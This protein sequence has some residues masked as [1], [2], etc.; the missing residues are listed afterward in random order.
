MFKKVILAVALA[1]PFSALAQKFGIVDLESVFQAMPETAAMQTQLTDTSKKYEEEFAKLQE[2]V[3]KLY[4]EYQNIQNDANTPESIKE[5]RIQ[6]IQERAQKVDQFRNTAQQ[7]LARLQET[8]MVPIQTKIQDAVKAVG[9][10]GSYTFIFPSDPGLLLYT[11]NDVVDVT[12][13]V[14]TKLGL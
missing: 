12:A 4:A 11:G 10:E 5:R 8:L 3:N 9:A 13:Q 1:L 6:E 7:D 2:E 14:R